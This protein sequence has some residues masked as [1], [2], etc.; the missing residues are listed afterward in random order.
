M[1]TYFDPTC[2]LKEKE[3]RGHLTAAQIVERLVDGVR[4]AESRTPGLEQHSYLII[5]IEMEI[6]YRI[7]VVC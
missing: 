4:G 6:P 5:K 3:K 1:S 2:Q 7:P